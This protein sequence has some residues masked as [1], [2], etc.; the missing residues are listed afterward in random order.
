M[1]QLTGLARA[2]YVRSMFAHIAARYDLMNHLMTA[3]QDRRWRKRVVEL[4]RLTP[5][6]SVLD[7]GCG[8]GD[9]ARAALSNFPQ[10]NVIAADFTLEM[11][12]AGKRS[13]A[14]NFS[15]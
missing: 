7:L 1:T 11:M 14:L 2:N 4:A 15:S 5:R 12:Q 13:G 8:T 3:G 10:A 9:M 6:A